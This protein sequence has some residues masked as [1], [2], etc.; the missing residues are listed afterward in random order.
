MLY[1]R[2]LMTPRLVAWYGDAGLD[3]R[4][5]RR[6]HP[7]DGW[8]EPLARLRRRLREE[9]GGDFNFVLL[10]RYRN[11]DDSMGWHRDDEA[12]IEKR[13]ASI[14]LG[15]DRRFLLRGETDP[16]STRIDLEDGSLLV[17]DGSIKH[18]LPRSRRP[19]GERINLTFRQVT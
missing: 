1:G 16:R 12:G 19:L 6:S 7:A 9:A 17:F 15:A 18:C 3:Y 10:N 2:R 5:S 4:Y 8:P 14:S 11:G 13:I